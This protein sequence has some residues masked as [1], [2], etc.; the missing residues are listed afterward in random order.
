MRDKTKLVHMPVVSTDGFSA[1]GA[2]VHRASTIVFPSSEAYSTRGDRGPEGYSYGLYGTPTTRILEAK[3]SQAAGA[4]RTLLVPSGQGANAIA[5]MALLSQGDHVLIP[6]TVYPAMRNLATH[7]LPRL[8][9]HAEFY[10]PTSLDDLRERFRAETKLVWCESPG[11]TTMEVQDYPAIVEIAHKGGALV[12]CDNTW[13][14]FISLKPLEM[15]F[16]IVSEAITKYASGHADVLLGAVMLADISIAEKIRG[17][18]G[19]IGIGVSPDDAWLALRGLETMYLRYAQ[20]R[21]GA[22]LLVQRFE[23][24]D[25]VERVLW[26]PLP[27]SP[28]HEIWQRDFRDAA[29]VFSVVFKDGASAGVPQAL[30]CLKVFAI[31]ASWGG[32]RSLVAPMSISRSRS[33]RPWSGDDMILRV[34]V[35]VED[36]LDLEDDIR[37]FLDALTKTSAQNTSETV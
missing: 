25:S 4:A 1:F 21:R 8:G 2:P 20:S 3:L 18:M 37:K 9:I 35:G 28:G 12:G 32:T 17:F 15:G 19:R 16:D 26:P 33:V 7:D 10:D 27:G 13:A 22:E 30:D 6:D 34:S 14:T 5:A 24:H 29:G 31:G 36:I 23:V 11:S